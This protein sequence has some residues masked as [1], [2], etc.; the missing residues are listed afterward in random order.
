MDSRNPFQ[1]L[2][3]LLALL[4]ILLASLSRPASGSE[5]ALYVPS[6]GG[7]VALAREIRA[8][9]LA[10]PV[11]LDGRLDESVWQGPSAA[12]L[13]Q[14][15]PVN[16]VAPRQR[17]DWWV[18]FDREALYVAARMFDA[19]PESIACDLA[20]RDSYH[21]SDYVFLNLG[22]FHDDRNGYSFNVNPAGAYADAVLYNDGW[23]DTSWDPIWDYGVAIDSLGWTAEIRIPFSQLDF[24][25]ADEQRWQINFSRR[26]L[27]YQERDELFHSPR[28]EEGYFRRFPD[29]VGIQGITRGNPLEVLAYAA[30]KG[31]F[32]DV[33]AGDPFHKGSDY[34]EQ[35]GA[36]AE[37]RLTSN[38]KLNGTVNPDFG[39]VEVDPAVVNLSDYETFLQER[40]PFFVEEA[41]TFNF[42]SEGTNSNWS[43]NW[44]DPE[45]FYSRRIGR[46]PSV[47]L[48][49]ADYTDLPSATTILAA[50]KLTGRIGGTKLGILSAMTSE[51]RARLSSGGAHTSAIAEPMANYSAARLQRS[52]QDGT[53]GLGFMATSVAR[54]LADASSHAQLTGSAL[55]GGLDGW[56]NFDHARKWAM[57]GYL[58]GSRVAGSEQAINAV[59][60]SS[61]HYLQRPERASDYDPSR[62]ALDGWM[63]RLMLN[64]QSGNITLNTAFAAVSPGFEINDL[65]YQTRADQLNAHFA[66]GYRW[67]EPKGI[68]RDRGFSVAAYSSWD[69]GGLP[70][71]GGLYSMW[72][73][74]FSNYWGAGGN[75]GYSPERNSNRVT[76]G[77]PIMRLPESTSGGIYV[78]S[79]SRRDVQG[80]LEFSFSQ[81][82]DGTNSRSTDLDLTVKPSSCCSI[83]FTPG[84]SVTNDMSA[85][86]GKVTDPTM[87][88]TGGTRYLYARM[89]LKELSFATRV[90]WTFTPR[91]TLQAYIQPLFAVAK[92]DGLM[93]FARPSAYEFN[94]YG[95]DNGSTIT[96]DPSSSVYTIDAD[97]PGPVEPFAISDPNFNF[98]SLKVNVVLRWEFLPGSTAYLVWTQNRQDSA[99]PGD[100]EFGRDARS[101]VEAPGE[102]VVMVKVT[103]WLKL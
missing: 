86:V 16:G 20:R 90:D 62:T 85:W 65:G 99:D 28:G 24:P 31:E 53:R 39:Q 58:V 67:R 45:L 82:A 93:E 87:T 13:I 15:D 89:N 63:G 70:D 40:R 2:L 6:S 56:L 25:K 61:R 23:D 75:L 8:K 72:D 49:A 74:T 97:G 95:R 71:A 100:F 101:L 4:A 88:A 1:S 94:R 76:R 98:K 55:A 30:G 54:D 27:R 19:A 3:S 64:K 29:L 46:A 12:P 83:G 21:P 10:E 57:R 5:T 96:Q 32:R 7:P 79:D 92:Y 48:N 84:Y 38:L 26:T 18:A 9:M 44:S 37:W 80:T 60:R 14:N 52:R 22:T 78:Q 47:S 103:R 69:Y 42:A 81:Q 73:V 50:G 34:D 59:Q 36:D 68:F 102:D 91:L 66:T 11:R 77:G 17:T 33:E 43:F 41:S 51:E 35:V